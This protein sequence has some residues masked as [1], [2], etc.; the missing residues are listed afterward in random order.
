MGR[1]SKS[2]IHGQERI[3]SQDPDAE[4]GSQELP[5]SEDLI[6]KSDDTTCATIPL[7]LREYSFWL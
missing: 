1:P 7:I 3:L 4:H 2:S 5:E 6:K